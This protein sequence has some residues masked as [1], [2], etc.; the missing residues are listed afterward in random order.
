MLLRNFRFSYTGKFFTLKH[1]FTIYVLNSTGLFFFLIPAFTCL[2]LPWCV[3]IKFSIFQH[4]RREYSIGVTILSQ[5]RKLWRSKSLSTY[6]VNM[7]EHISRRLRASTYD[8][9]SHICNTNDLLA[10]F[11]YYRYCCSYNKF[12]VK[13][14][15]LKYTYSNAIERRIRLNQFQKSDLASTALPGFIWPWYTRAHHFLLCFPASSFP[16]DFLPQQIIIDQI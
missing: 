11:S 9:R 5:N 16:S 1:S 14:P 8:L 6:S 2:I 12:W 7:C 13:L 15:W 3:F 4:W 10:I